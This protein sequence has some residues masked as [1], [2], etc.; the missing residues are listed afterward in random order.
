[1]EKKD[2]YIDEIYHFKGKWEMPS[3]CGL[4]IRKNDSN[5]VIILTE[6]Y[7]EN[8]GS[9]VTDVIGTLA[10]ELVKKFAI[11]AETAIFVVRNPQRS[12]HY[13]FYAESFHRARMHWDGERYVGLRWERLEDFK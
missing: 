12:V 1:M 5:P 11:P 9:S 4:M 8:P 13:N 10:G 3:L 7:A 2:E 6:L